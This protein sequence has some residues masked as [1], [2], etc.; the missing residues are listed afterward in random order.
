M[1]SLTLGDWP[2][3]HRP[4][5]I[6]IHAAYLRAARRAGIKSGWMFTTDDVASRDKWTC[7]ACGHAVPRTWTTAE[8]ATA[9]ALT[10]ATPW[11]HGGQYD[12]ANARLAHYGCIAF[13]DP[14]LARAI[15]QALTSDLTAPVRAARDDETCLYGHPLTGPNL[16]KN[17]DG[18]RR[19]RQCR[20]DRES[21]RRAAFQ[22]ST[23]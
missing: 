20:N 16:L 21:G 14:A 10:F 2:P 8:L 22:A 6:R 3:G 12:K 7:H 23:A 1:D 4:R 9:P 15:A 18:R 17:A 11:A 19:C 13:A 5:R